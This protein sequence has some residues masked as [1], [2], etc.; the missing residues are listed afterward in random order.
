MWAG[1]KRQWFLVAL[2]VCFAVGFFAAEP[3]EFLLGLE[4]L[5]GAIVF[6]VMWATGVTLRADA[7]RRSFVAPLPALLAISIN[8]ALVPALSLP[9]GWLLPES[10]LPARLAGGLF[11]AALV[12]CT[13]A[14]AAV[15]TRKAGGDDSVALLTTAVT[16]LACV[17][18]VPVG[19][20]IGLGRQADVS[21][22]GQ[23][24]K[25]ALLV[26]APLVLAQVVRRLG[27]GPWA[28]RHK[29][30]LAVASQI[31]ILAMV[32]FGAIAS[33]RTIGGADESLSAVPLGLAVLIAAALAIHLAAF[34]TGVSLARGLGVARGGQIAVGFAGSQ[35]TLMVGLQIAI[36]CG[37]SVVPMIV[38]HL[39]QL[40]VDT[41]IADRWRR[42]A[43][44]SAGAGEKGAKAGR[45][46]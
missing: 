1:L 33:A 27:A 25:L 46:P 45:G 15:W 7:I 32:V 21:A 44:A 40:F 22:G 2:G 30:R 37:V 31:G 5:R 39:G 3:L 4:W 35:K 41:L 42:G 24:V 10:V 18:V 6:G 20:L 12:P 13:L 29:I 23:M 28:D 8:V 11:V 14:S 19:V 36:D 17:V 9:L 38:Y 16:N 34:G 26:A 43:A